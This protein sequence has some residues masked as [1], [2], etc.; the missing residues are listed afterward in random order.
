MVVIRS[1]RNSAQRVIANTKTAARTTSTTSTTSRSSQARVVGPRV[2]ATPTPTPSLTVCVVC[3]EPAEC[4]DT[5]AAGTGCGHP[6][7]V[8]RPCLVRVENKKC[9]VCRAPLDSV[10]PPE[11]K[12][13]RRDRTLAQIREQIDDDERYAR[14]LS[15]FG[16]RYEHLSSEDGVTE[17]DFDHE[18]HR[19]HTE[20]ADDDEH[21]VEVP[22]VGV[23]TNAPGH[24]AYVSRWVSSLSSVWA[25]RAVVQAHR[26][27][28]NVIRVS[29]SATRG[30]QIR[31]GTTTVVSGFSVSIE[32]D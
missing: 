9:P 21:E 18:Q 8:C 10:V 5:A 30:G 26:F 7:Q 6:P 13:R 2:R 11:N 32:I 14:Q 3:Y 15:D 25:P 1:G 22:V 23:R 31:S 29:A 19:A 24:G 12:R 20:P 4:V 16:S 28:S 27:P 17:E